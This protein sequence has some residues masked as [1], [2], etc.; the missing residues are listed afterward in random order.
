MVLDSV[1]QTSR[2]RE[3]RLNPGRQNS[4]SLSFVTIPLAWASVN[5]RVAPPVGVLMQ[6]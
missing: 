3:E 2:R 4:D 5:R 1:F 6:F